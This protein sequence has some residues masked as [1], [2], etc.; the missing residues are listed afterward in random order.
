MPVLQP[1][2]MM[3][4]QRVCQNQPERNESVL[5][6][7]RVPENEVED[8]SH[9]VAD[10]RLSS[11]YLTE[12][13]TDKAQHWSPIRPTWKAII[14]VWSLHRIGLCLMVANYLNIHKVITTVR[15]SPD[16]SPLVP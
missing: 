6:H 15:A 11:V 13:R 1:L 9:D 8:D 3:H 5:F 10:D 2:C 4:I 14:A 7:D 16:Q 12:S